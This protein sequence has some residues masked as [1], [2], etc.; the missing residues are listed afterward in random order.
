MDKDTA[1]DLALE[2]LIYASSY[3]DTYDAIT[4]IK[5]ARSAPVQEP[6]AWSRASFIEDDDG[7]QIGTDEPEISWGK[8]P[9]DKFGWSP[10]YTTPP[11][12]PAPVQE[13]KKNT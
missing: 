6:V 8:E 12:Q 7:R 1:L 13:H 9:P 4:A 11:A 5:Q 2:A 3:C 10:L